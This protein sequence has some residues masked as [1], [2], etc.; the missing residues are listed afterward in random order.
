MAKVEV[1]GEVVGIVF[2]N[3]GVQIAEAYTS[4]DG[5]RRET[6]FTAWLDAP[7]N[8]EIGQKVTAK[9]LLSAS[10]R[11]YQSKDGETKTAL[12]LNINF[13]S[14]TVDGASSLLGTPMSP[15]HEELPF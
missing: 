4:K 9:G 3:K 15:T 1:N 13:A 14:V 10:T 7:T 6:R 5:K 8:L 2:E 11:E 12:N